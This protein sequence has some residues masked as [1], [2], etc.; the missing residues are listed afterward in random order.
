[1]EKK[2]VQK[3]KK[4]SNDSGAEHRLQP[5]VVAFDI[6]KYYGSVYVVTDDF[7]FYKIEKVTSNRRKCHN[8]TFRSVCLSGELFK[9]HR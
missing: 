2:R 7:M 3:S 5:K 1:M 6:D 8:S 4:Y 9:K